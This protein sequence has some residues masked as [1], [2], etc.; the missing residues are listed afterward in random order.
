MSEAVAHYFL[1]L[2]AYE[3]EYEVARLYTS[4]DFQKKLEARFSRPFKLKFHLAPPLIARRD[5][6]SGELKKRE[7]GPWVFSVFKVLASLKFLRGTRLDIF[8][9]TAERR[10]ERE[11]ITDYE[12]TM[13]AEILERLSPESHAMAVAIPQ[14]TGQIR[15]YGNFAM[16]GGG[17]HGDVPKNL[18]EHLLEEPCSC[19]LLVQRISRDPSG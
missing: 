7:F 15:G 14:L 1:K 13:F 5:P 6:V 4:G 11:L 10:T 19:P 8:G 9:Y 16:F 3:D 2:L 17:R 12:R 18:R